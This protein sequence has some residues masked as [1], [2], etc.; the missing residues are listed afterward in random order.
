MCIRDSK[1]IEAPLAQPDLEK[2]LAYKSSNSPKSD[3]DWKQF[4]CS[5]CKD[6]EDKNLVAIGSRNWEIHL[7]SRRHKTNI[8]RQHKKKS[9]EKWQKK[10]LLEMDSSS[11]NSH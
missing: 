7:K 6:K 4:S 2:L 8:N 10:K 5:L 9:Y 3:M 11:I 1:D